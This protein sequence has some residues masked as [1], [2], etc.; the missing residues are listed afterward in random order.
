MGRVFM[1]PI[2]VIISKRGLD[3]LILA[4]VSAA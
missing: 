3:D 2:A 4:K 1:G